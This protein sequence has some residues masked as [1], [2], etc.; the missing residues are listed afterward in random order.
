MMIRHPMDD[1]IHTSALIGLL[2]DV[3]AVNSSSAF[4][5]VFSGRNVDLDIILEPD[6]I[7]TKSEKQTINTFN[8]VVL[9]T[10]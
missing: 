3:Q 8:E 10:T 2:D 9:D 5:K 6:Q 4:H 7:R 1:K